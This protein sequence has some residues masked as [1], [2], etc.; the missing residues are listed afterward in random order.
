MEAELQQGI[1]NGTFEWVQ[2]NNQISVEYQAAGLLPL[3]WVY[4]HKL[5]ANN[6]L[7]KFK[8]RLCAR[9][10]L[11]STSIDTYAATLAARAFRFLMAL[12]CQFN[13]ECEQ[14]DFVAAYL[15][16]KLDEPVFARVPEGITS[17]GVA[18]KVLRA[19]YGLKQSGALWQGDLTAFLTSFG[20][21]L[22][23]GLECVFY[24]DQLIV[25]FSVDDSCA[26][27]DGKNRAEYDRLKA[28][29]LDRYEMHVLGSL[30]WFLG[31][32]IVRDRQAKTLYVVQD[33]FIE[34]MAAKF[35]V[36]LPTRDLTTGL[37]AGGLVPMSPYVDLLVDA[38]ITAST[39]EI[40]AYKLRI[41]SINYPA[42]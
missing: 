3:K 37:L 26:V 4:R 14:F 2:S 11:Q 34:K 7:E 23:P 21:R 39:A 17:K 8:S 29:L 35:A 18:L 10:D 15:N 12:V 6:E 36:T 25:F 5:N 19:L 16:V 27:F 32:R 31:M 13:L 30:D 9:G 33:S 20:L 38:N 24:S 42:A 28:V 22:V 41:R 1:N 40:A